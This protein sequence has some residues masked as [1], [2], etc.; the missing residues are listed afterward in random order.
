MQTHPTD[1]PLGALGV[2]R[3][4]PLIDTDAPEQMAKLAD[5]LLRADLP[6]T[7]VTLRRP[8]SL[9]ALKELAQDPDMIVGAGTVMTE[10]QA[11]EAVD[12]GA[13]FGDS[14]G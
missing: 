6:V 4:L 14:D 2:R 13:R 11:A 12:A 5:A 9:E 10:H 1:S 8:H 7:E 3:I